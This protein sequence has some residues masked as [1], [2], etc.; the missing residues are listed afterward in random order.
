MCDELHCPKQLKMIEERVGQ[1]LSGAIE[2]MMTQSFPGWG[3]SHGTSNLTTGGTC[4]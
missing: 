1:E 3:F 2:K 4:S